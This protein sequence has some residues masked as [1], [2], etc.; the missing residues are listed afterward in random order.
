MFATIQ[1]LAS[2]PEKVLVQ[3]DLGGDLPFM[4]LPWTYSPEE[5]A[6][7]IHRATGADPA[8]GSH[9]GD[10]RWLIHTTEPDEG[11][12]VDLLAEVDD[13]ITIVAVMI[14]R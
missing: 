12:T 13:Y 2:D 9:M 8:L 7:M 14:R 5:C 6:E 4:S 10:H 1:K 3:L 11:D